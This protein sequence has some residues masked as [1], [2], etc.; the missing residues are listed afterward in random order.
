ME[1][2]L[3]PFAANIIHTLASNAIGRN[4]G[5]KYMQFRKWVQIMFLSWQDYKIT[6]DCSIIPHFKEGLLV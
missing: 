3:I 5:G 4:Y 2:L 6:L 1:V